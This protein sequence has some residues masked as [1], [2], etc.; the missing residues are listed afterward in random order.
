MSRLRASR[1]PEGFV[2]HLSWLLTSNAAGALVAVAQG[3][4]VARVLGPAG[5]GQ[6]VL[7]INLPS[8]V[9]TFLDARSTEGTT[10]F[11]AEFSESDDRAGYLSLC[12]HAYVLDLAIG[13]LAVVLVAALGPWA[14]THIARSAEAYAA[15]LIYSLTFLPLAFANTSLAVLSLEG[16]FAQ[17]A[18]MQLAARAI[19][20][21]AVAGLLAAGLGWAGYVYGAAFGQVVGA[22]LLAAAARRFF[23]SEWGVGWWSGKWSALKGQRGR[24][25][26]FY[27]MTDLNAL[28]GL[29]AKQL[30]VTVLGYLTGSA[31]VGMYK[32][33]KTIAGQLQQFVGP[34]QLVAY[35]RVSREAAKSGR[36]GLPGL[37]MGLQAWVG[38]PALA[39]SLLG[40]AVA[41]IL[42]PFLF[43]NSFVGAVP[44]FQVLVVAG[45]VAG[46]LF[47][48]RPVFYTTGRIRAWLVISA[49][50][51]TLTVIGYAFAVPRWGAL[52]IAYVQLSLVI[53]GHGVALAW[54]G[55]ASKM[56]PR[57]ADA[58]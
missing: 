57:E 29:A 45:G 4:L 24:L 51:A 22:L 6:A 50:V 15:M 17:V 5:Y 46:L 55:L 12:K 27:G 11:L 35:P 38:L 42:I 36:R 13:G 56:R 23:R 37:V 48:L 30:D 19:Q 26:R 18:R 3:V 34:A 40:A 31:Q 44:M 47:W 39:V 43:G 53:F 58:A 20:L 7:V 14:A 28:L 41:P 10:K 1:L 32:L 2:G 54:L 49:V 16:R 8:V 21:L 25:A 52:G 9:Y 33:A